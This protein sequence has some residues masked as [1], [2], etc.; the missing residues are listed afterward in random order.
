MDLTIW[1][2]TAKDGDFEEDKQAPSALHSRSCW[3]AAVSDTNLAPGADNDDSCVLKEQRVTL[4]TVLDKHTPKT[5]VWLSI[6]L[7]PVGCFVV[8]AGFATLA[9]PST[10]ADVLHRHALAGSH[11][12]QRHMMLRR[13]VMR[14]IF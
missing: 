11:T 8:S 13:R 1:L 12:S 5:A 14:W 3:L 7:V 9:L 10:N 6:D 2:S 4:G